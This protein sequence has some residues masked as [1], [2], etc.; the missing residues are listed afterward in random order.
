MGNDDKISIRTH[1]SLEF[2][3][4]F[5]DKLVELEQQSKNELVLTALMD[6]RDVLYTVAENTEDEYETTNI[7]VS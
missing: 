5:M 3:C 1:H 4:C 7:K 2:L 6:I